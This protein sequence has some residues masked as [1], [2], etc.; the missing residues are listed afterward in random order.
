MPGD[1][2]H[3]RVFGYRLAAIERRQ[4]SVYGLSWL[5]EEPPVWSVIVTSNGVQPVEVSFP[6]TG[7][8][9]AQIIGIE[10]PEG[11]AIRYEFQPFGPKGRSVRTPA[12]GSRRMEGFKFMEWSE[13]AT[14][15]FVDAADLP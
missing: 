13:G 11:R 10:V 14:F 3:V 15:C 9:N 7:R 6:D 12:V 8:D 1:P 2:F 5:A 4:L